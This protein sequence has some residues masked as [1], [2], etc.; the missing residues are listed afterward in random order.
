[1][2]CCLLAFSFAQDLSFLFIENVQPHKCG[3]QDKY[4]STFREYMPNKKKRY[5]CKQTTHRKKPVYHLVDLDSMRMI[6][7]TVLKLLPQTTVAT[8]FATIRV[9]S[10]VDASPSCSDTTLFTKF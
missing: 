8:T 5:F 4:W 7:A 10:L 2:N 9:Y 3:N 1:M 6:I